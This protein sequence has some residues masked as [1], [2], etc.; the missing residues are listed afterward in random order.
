MSET[1]NKMFFI[2]REDGS[3]AAWS[4]HSP[5]LAG[6]GQWSWL[7]IDDQGVTFVRSL[8]ETEIMYI[9]QRY[10]VWGMK[11]EKEPWALVQGLPTLMSSSITT[12]SFDPTRSV[13]V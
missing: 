11:L 6:V 2:S 5:A 1:C 3:F 9:R 12:T 10:L 8:C 7:A 13:G 4:L